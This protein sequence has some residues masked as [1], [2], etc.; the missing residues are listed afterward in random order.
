MNRY[1]LARLALLVPVF[2][3]ASIVVFSVM[4]LTPGDPAVLM[5]GTEATAEN[6]ARLREEL[7]LNEPLPFQYVKWLARVVR[8]DLGDSLWSKRSVAAEIAPKLQATIILAV[9]SLVLSTV[10]GVLAGIISAVRRNSWFDRVSIVTALV[11]VSM[12]VF[13]LGFVLMAIFS[14]ELRLLPPT[15]MYSPTGGDLPDMLRHLILP[16]VTLAAPSLAVLARVTRSAM[17]EVI[18]QDYV[19]TAR[20]KGLAE[21]TIAYRHALRNALIPVIT[22]VGVQVGQLL[23]GAILVETVFSWPGLG[24]LLLQGIGT[25][26]FPVVQGVA[27]VS[28]MI[29][30]VVNLLVDLLYGYVDPRIRYA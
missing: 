12:P 13:W 8:G 5:L 25:R 9:A 22:L 17:L 30:S 19:R 2:F 1:V 16:A 23:S 14:V 26:D 7:G 11:G 15:G 28:A 29:F 6:V 21:P 3:G 27:L 4:R 10:I 18:N 20:A 24:S